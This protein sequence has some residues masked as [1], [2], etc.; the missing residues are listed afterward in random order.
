MGPT[1]SQVRAYF[2]AFSRGYS[3]RGAAAIAGISLRAAEQLERRYG[4]EG[5]EPIPA[6]SEEE[7]G[8][9]PRAISAIR[10]QLAG[11]PFGMVKLSRPRAGAPRSEVF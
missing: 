10:R 6:P 9:R 11:D 3:R 2:E 4:R 5:S 7:G 8:S 1:P